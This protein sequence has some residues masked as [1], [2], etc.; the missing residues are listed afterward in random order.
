MHRLVDIFWQH[1]DSRLS[2]KP[3]GRF[4]LEQELKRMHRGR[5]KN[6]YTNWFRQPGLSSISR[7]DVRLSD[8][9]D[10][11]NA[12]SVAPTE[13][14]TPAPIV[15]QSPDFQ[16]ELPFPSQRRTVSL[17]LEATETALTVRIFR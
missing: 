10:V 8:L 4:H 15:E 5:N 1:V 11:A 17:E 14:I 2:D 16:L 7:P 6:T 3:R 12:L 9:E 13:L